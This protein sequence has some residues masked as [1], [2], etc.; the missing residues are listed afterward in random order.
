MKILN[1]NHHLKQYGISLL[2]GEACA[3]NMR[4]LCDL[5]QKGKK[6]ISGYLG[7]PDCTFAPN[8]NSTVDDEPAVASIMLPR[9]VFKELNI[10]ILFHV[11]KSDIAISFEDI[12]FYGLKREDE[13]YQSYLDLANEH[14]GIKV[15]RNP[16]NT[17]PSENG[18]N[19][20][21]FTGRTV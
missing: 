7:L 13:Y 9:C 10:Y 20:H 17:A 1:G 14:S 15:Y 8:W 19:I 2:T 3:Y 18:R 11:E 16:C 4:V 6:L 21:Q 5:S 12:S